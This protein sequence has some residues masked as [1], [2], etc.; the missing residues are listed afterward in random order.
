[1]V[2]MGNIARQRKLLAWVSFHLRIELPPKQIVLAE[3]R[4][5]FRIQGFWPEIWSKRQPC[6]C[7]AE[8]TLIK[9][10]DVKRVTCCWYCGCVCGFAGKDKLYSGWSIL[11]ARAVTSR[12][13][14]IS[15]PEA[16]SVFSISPFKRS[17]VAA[18]FLDADVADDRL[19]TDFL[20]CV[21]NLIRKVISSTIT[22]ALTGL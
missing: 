9:H 22:V 20:R 4:L 7:R 13:S 8:R 19:Q 3:L 12:Y 18:R 5:F 17:H 16:N 11:I 6:Q 1:M 14:K 2:G 15:E 21:V 10:L